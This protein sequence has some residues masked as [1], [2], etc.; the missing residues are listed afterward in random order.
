MALKTA[1]NN[2]PWCGLDYSYD[3]VDLT[4]VTAV[5]SMSTS[6]C[7]A[8]IKVTSQESSGKSVYVMAI[9]QGGVQLDV[10]TDAF[11]KLFGSELGQFPAKWEEV[12]SSHCSGILRGGSSTASSKGP[13]ESSNGTGKGKSRKPKKNLKSE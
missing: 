3:K 9:D 12:A 5:Q 10:S 4:R 6:M 13:K 7:G 11:K 1:V 8:C 2:P